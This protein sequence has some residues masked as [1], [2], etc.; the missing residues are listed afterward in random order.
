MSS[1]SLAELVDA[2]RARDEAFSEFDLSV[3]PLDVGGD[4]AC[5]E[6]TVS[7]T[8][9]GPVAVDD[10]RSI[11]ATGARVRIHGVTVAEFDGGRICAVRQYWD[12]LSLLTQLDAGT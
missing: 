2:L 9:T 4:Y 10:L 11:E 1:T 6:W 3:G 5:A 8:H 7:M 12:P